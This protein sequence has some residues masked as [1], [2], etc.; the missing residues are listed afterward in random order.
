MYVCLYEHVSVCSV[1]VSKGHC[2]KALQTGRLKRIERYSFSFL[3]ALRETVSQAR[4]Q[5]A[6]GRSQSRGPQLGGAVPAFISMRCP[7]CV[8]V[9]LWVCFSSSRGASHF[10]FWAV[11]LTDC[12]CKDTI[13][14]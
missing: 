12:I 10:R 14:K 13:S 8:S 4:L 1:L 11:I 7:H 3:E 2:N 9:S 6:G 5:A